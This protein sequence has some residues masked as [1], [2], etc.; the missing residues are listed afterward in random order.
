MLARASAMLNS[1]GTSFS[2]SNEVNGE[3]AACRVN[4]RSRKSCPEG[5]CS[6]L[7]TIVF[8][9]NETLLDLAALDPLFENLFGNNCVRT[10]WFLT[11]QE[12]WMT[13]VIT[14]QYQPFGDLAQAALNMV[15]SR[16]QVQIGNHQCRE[17]TDG[18]TS[19]PPHKD[20]RQALQMLSDNGFVLVA[21]SNSALEAL[22]KQ[23]DS[24]GLTDCFDYIMA[25]SEISRFKPA[26]QTYQMVADRLSVNTDQ[27]IMVAAHAWDI[28]GA[29]RA[30]CKTAFVER[31]GK[32][33]NPIGTKPDWIGKDLEDVARKICAANTEAS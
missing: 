5:T 31:P 14:G 9:V 16:H 30:G 3:P 28:A 27:M 29:A 12:C 8:D 20:V 1:Q 6:M 17:L 33:L 15:G 24:S 4:A 26:L 11:L 7:K 25:G 23:L 22:N 19:L 13:N 10:E 18:I 2:L 21:L 32:V